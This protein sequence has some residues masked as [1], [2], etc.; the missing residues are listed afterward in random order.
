MITIRLS[1]KLL[2]EEQLLLSKFHSLF[3]NT[4][5]VWVDLL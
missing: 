2:R 4:I 5:I 1:K 3:I